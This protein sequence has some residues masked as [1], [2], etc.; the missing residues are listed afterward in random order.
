MAFGQLVIGPPGSGKTTYC[1]G[2]QQFLTAIGRPMAIVNLDPA[3]ERVPYECSIDIGELVCLETVMAELNL[4][5]NGGMIYCMEYLAKNMD[6]LH[7]RLQALG[8]DVYLLFDCP[9]QVELYTTNDGML[10][11]VRTLTQTWNLRLAA[12][13]LVDSHHCSDA[14]KYLSVLLVSLSTMVQLELPHINVLSKIDLVESFGAL[15]FELQFYTDVENLDRLLDVHASATDRTPAQAALTAR[16]RSLTRALAE[17]IQMFSMV[18]FTTLNIQEKESVFALLSLV[19]KTN[20]YVYSGMHNDLLD[21]AIADLQWNYERVGI[22]QEK[23]VAERP[24]P[25]DDLA[26]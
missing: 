9:G 8:P 6:W 18:S 22:V 10:Q 23:Y 4:G 21:A 26:A 20:G 14:Y 5:P 11:V 19:D 1:N 17:L 24:M 12:V 16:Y 7:E 13:H 3:N 2:M 15:A 25:F